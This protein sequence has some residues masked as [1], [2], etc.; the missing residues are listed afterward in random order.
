MARVYVPASATSVE[1]GNRT[2]FYQGLHRGVF[3]RLIRDL[4]LAIRR[5]VKLLAAGERYPDRT[6]RL[7]A[8][9]HIPRIRGISG[10]GKEASFPVFDFDHPE[11]LPLATPPDPDERVDPQARLFGAAGW[12]V[13]QATQ[14][15]TGVQEKAL[16]FRRSTRQSLR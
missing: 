1:Q 11:A 10:V 15:C 13:A 14:T 3:G 12:N 4:G 8:D 16:H 5:E 9:F 2:R 6:I 7:V